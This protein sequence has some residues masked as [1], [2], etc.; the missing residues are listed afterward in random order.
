LITLLA[1]RVP[2]RMI[3]GPRAEGVKGEVINSH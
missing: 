1:Q 2:A 3:G